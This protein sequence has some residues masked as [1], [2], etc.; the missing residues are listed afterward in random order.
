[1]PSPLDLDK[2]G[3]LLWLMTT[4]PPDKL[5]NGTLSGQDFPEFDN[6]SNDMQNTFESVVAVM[7]AKAPSINDLERAQDIFRRAFTSNPQMWSTDHFLLPEQI[8]EIMR[9]A[10][11]FVLRQTEQARQYERGETG[12]DGKNS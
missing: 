4:A 8:V 5:R 12:G 2:F 7:T 6:L 3:A 9:L 1:M 11:G 10:P